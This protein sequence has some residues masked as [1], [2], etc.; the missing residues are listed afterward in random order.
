M[1]WETHRSTVAWLGLGSPVETVPEKFGIWVMLGDGRRV[2]PQWTLIQ[3]I[4]GLVRELGYVKRAGWCKQGEFTNNNNKKA[5]SH[6]TRNSG[7]PLLGQQKG[8]KSESNSHSGY[9]I[10]G[11]NNDEG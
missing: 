4:L 6:S 10:K 7:M 3:I 11:W 1:Q 9:L 5:L 2:G 8:R